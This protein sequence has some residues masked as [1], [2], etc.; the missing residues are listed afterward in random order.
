MNN[1]DTIVI[2][3][4]PAGISCAIYLKR[5]NLNPLVLTTKNSAL[6]NAK[7]ENYYGIKSISGSDL[8]QQGIDQAAALGIDI[9]YEC[10]TAIEYDNNFIVKTDSTSYSSKTIYIATGMSRKKSNIK[11]LDKFLGCGVS[12]CATCDGFFFRNKR[13]GIVGSE[14]FMESELEVLERFSKNI[15]IFSDGV[16][17]KNDKF[18]VVN[19]KIL[20]VYGDSKLKGLKTLNNDYELDALFLAIGNANACDFAAHLGLEI[21][22]N[23]LVV[24]ENFM[25]NFKGVFAGG[26]A[27]GGMLQVSKAV[28]DGAR[29]ALAIKNYLK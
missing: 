21:K 10:V 13:I 26:D 17:Y 22:N 15:T 18:M 16:L 20:E 25:T 9:K 28:S 12:Q 19:D 11:N 27:I 7:I 24:D 8:W 3:S 5:Y 1:Y 29:S 14:K 6:F 2:G 23:N 4:G